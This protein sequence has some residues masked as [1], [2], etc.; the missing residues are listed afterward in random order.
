M[1]GYNGS[2]S[3]LNVPDGPDYTIWL[4]NSTRIGF[5]IIKKISILS[6]VVTAFL[7]E[8]YNS[9]QQQPE[10]LTNHIFMQLAAQISHLSVNGHSVNFTVPDFTTP[11][12]QKSSHRT[13]HCIPWYSRQTMVPRTSIL[14]DP[15]PNGATQTPLLP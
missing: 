12:F 5:R 4:V 9:L 10:D 15:R 7:I 1:T 3:R 13:N 14:R 8:S 6:A 2:G 11:P